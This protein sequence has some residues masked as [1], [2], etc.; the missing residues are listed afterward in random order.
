M[1]AD[2][3]AMSEEELEDTYG[4]AKSIDFDDLEANEEPLNQE[5]E[6]LPVPNKTDV[7]WSDY[8]LAQL[9]ETEYYNGKPTVHG[10]RRIAEKFIGQIYESTTDVV[11]APSKDNDFRATV[12]VTIA[13][14][15]A[16]G[17]T[18][19]YSGAADVY[20]G[21]TDAPFHKYPVATAETRAEA[22][23]LSRALKLRTV[24]AEEVSNVANQNNEP[25][26]TN[27]DLNNVQNIGQDLINNNQ[28]NMMDILCKNNQRGMDINVK[29]LVNMGKQTYDT[30]RKVPY[31]KAA[32]MIKVLS[33]YQRKEKVIPDK[34]KG[35]DTNWKES[36]FYGS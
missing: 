5:P 20:S 8:V 23:A 25:E 14:R 3:E 19:L 18:G 4:N 35:Y 29:S 10:L 27:T 33:E 30:I 13:L 31:D 26:I 7:E 1:E 12:V 9:D 34:I 21:N 15:N 16:D 11:A 22:R 17:L 32:N 6:P 2:V 36:E 24:G 28:I